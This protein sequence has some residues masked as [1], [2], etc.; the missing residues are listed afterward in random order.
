MVDF[1]LVLIKLRQL[2][3]LR[4]YEQ[5]LVKTVV[6][7]RGVGHFEHKFQGEE[8]SSTSDS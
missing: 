5:I 8:G 1:L 3:Q 4:H 6:L 2:S 7:E